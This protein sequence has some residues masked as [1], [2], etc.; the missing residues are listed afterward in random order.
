MDGQRLE[1]ALRQGPPFATRYVASS[2]ALDAQSV[3]RGPVSVGRLVLILAVTALLLASMLAGLAALGAFRDD[4]GPVSN[5]WIAFARFGSGPSGPSGWVE[6]DIYLVREDEAAH[7][8]VGSDADSLDEVCPAFSPDG[9]RLAHGE[10]DGTEGDGYHHAALVISDLD[11]AGNAS[12]SLRIDVGGTRPPPC[13]VWSADGRRVAFAFP[14]DPDRLEAGSEVWVATVADGHV[15]V[16]SDLPASD[17]EWSPDGS[18]LAI[19]IGQTDGRQSAGEGSIRLYDADRREMR[20]LV[21]P[22]PAGVWKLTWSPDGSRIAYQRGRS[23][24]GEWDQE[25][26]VVQVDGGG[27][28]L[29]ARRFGS[30]Y[31]VGPV[32]SPTGDRIVYQRTKAGSAHDV[33]L[34]TPDDGSEDVLPDLRLPGDDASVSWR[35]DSVTWSPDGNELLYTAWISGRPGRALISRPLDR[36]SHPVVLQEDVAADGEN[37][38]W[39]RLPDE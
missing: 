22:G 18:Q 7:R 11:A 12:E 9:R 3:V 28:H 25:I 14:F 38:S 29:I 37:R 23:D 13:A 35:P 1:R 30:H 34:V 33:V 32:W 4:D 8:I 16:V 5:G 15:D 26:W 31:G 27:E 2:L 6:R 24:G 17:L 20:T 21:G 19:A 36:G 39:G 10:A